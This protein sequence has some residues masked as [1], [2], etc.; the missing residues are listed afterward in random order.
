MPGPPDVR[1]AS[2][3]L[4][5]AL[6]PDR[7]GDIATARYR[8]RHGD[9]TWRMLWC[10]GSHAPASGL[11][12]LHGRWIPDV[13]VF[14]DVVAA[15]AKGAP[16]ADALSTALRFGE[17]RAPDAIHAIF[18]CADGGRPTCVQNTTRP[19]ELGSLDEPDTLAGYL[20]D[21]ADGQVIHVPDLPEPI[22]ARVEGLDVVHLAAQ[23][24][25]DPLHTTPSLVLSMSAD[26]LE[27]DVAR[28]AVARIVPAVGVILMV[29]DQLVRLRALAAELTHFLADASH[30]LR[31]PLTS[32]V[33]YAELHRAGGLT[34]AASVD[35]V[36]GRIRL[37]S[38]RLLGL[39]EDLLLLAELG[40]R[41][42]LRV[43]T[44]DLG[45]LAR[46]VAAD[47]VAAD[48]TRPITIEVDASGDDDE[49]VVATADADRVRQILTNLVANAR[50]HTPAGSPIELAV[51]D[52]GTSVSM[53]VIDHGPGLGPDE[54]MAAFRRFWRGETARAHD[55]EGR[56]LGLPIALALTEANGGTLTVDTTPGSGATFTVRLPAHRVI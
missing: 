11:N 9:G 2:G 24:V 7:R 34:D 52:D 26:E 35:E 46:E 1:S 19:L 4:A 55:D 37:E 23:T 22:R 14:D 28:H 31:T 49:A 18:Y 41:R 17:T 25:V 53:K 48:P 13:E 20:R 15:I 21:R 36:M 50:S 10:N 12:V 38:R 16:T 33:G 30:E 3:A 5:R 51:A 6:D 42:P 27:P 56:G 54:S 29:R 47:A 45:A 8:L 43:S 39:V 44:F 40:L 32:I